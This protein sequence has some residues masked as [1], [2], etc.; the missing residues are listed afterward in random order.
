MTRSLHTSFTASLVA[1]AVLLTGCATTG[2][3]P[4]GGVGSGYRPIIDT[5]VAGF[6]PVKFEQDLG[7][8]QR[9][10]ANISPAGNAVGAAIAGALFGALVAAAAGGG[11]SRNSAAGVGAV[12]AA[13]GGAGDALQQQQNVIR[14]CLS[15][16]GY[17]VLG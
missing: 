11:Y 17:S 13:A 1:A 10:A 9:Y 6:N 16:R 8:C 3:H 4:S 15:G 5:A 12:S 2:Q 14:R 7:E